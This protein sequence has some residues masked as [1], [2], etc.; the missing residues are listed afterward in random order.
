MKSA[1]GGPEWDGHLLLL[2]SHESQRRNGVEAWVRRGLEI[3]AKILYTEPPD[4]APARSFAG[5]LRDQPAAVEALGTGQIQVFPADQMAYDPEWQASVLDR[6]LGQ[7]PCV[8]WGGEATT[9]WGL[10]S[11]E[12]HTEIEEATDEMCA[13]RPV[14][15]LCQYPARASTTVLES[16]CATHHAGLRERLV[17]TVPLGQG[18]IAVFGDVDR[19]NQN[20][21]YSVL[22]AATK[23]TA[24]D[25]FVVDLSGLRFL[26]V[27]GVRSLM[28]GTS[29]YRR[30]GGHVL[31]K[32][33]PPVG[34]VI[35]L[36][37]ERSRGLIVEDRR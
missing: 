9:A 26:D 24:P 1:G 20:I 35:R 33:R 17:R 8:R 25:P 5:L 19:S 10:M 29:R 36:L 27:G 11:R 37:T 6:A 32:A 7:Y 16:A 15:A 30:L 4:E 18:G 2:Y 12:R 34:R 21:L 28:I 31:V 14:S 13:S 3:G 23:T 22:L